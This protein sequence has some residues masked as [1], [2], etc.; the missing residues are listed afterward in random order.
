MPLPH[1]PRGPPSGSPL[2]SP[3][4]GVSRCP[5]TA[6]SAFSRNRGPLPELLSLFPSLLGITVLLL[7]ASLLCCLSVLH[8]S[9]GFLSSLALPGPVLPR[10]L[11]STA[12]LILPPPSPGPVPS[13]QSF[14]LSVPPRTRTTGPG[15][16]TSSSLALGFQSHQF[17]LLGF[18]RGEEAGV[19]AQWGAELQGRC[20]GLRRGA[21][22]SLWAG[23]GGSEAGGGSGPT[24]GNLAASSWKWMV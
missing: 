5:F 9:R 6:P 3:S 7:P 17:S 10:V 18:S 23:G 19:T 22:L 8:H 13:A 1:P 16:G 4:F 12:E 24:W 15:T 14:P 21:Q 20:R 2:I 11:K